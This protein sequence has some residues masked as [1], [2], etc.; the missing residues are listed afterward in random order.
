MASNP[1]PSRLLP[2]VTPLKDVVSILYTTGCAVVRPNSLWQEPQVCLPYLLDWNG[3][4][5][6]SNPTSGL[7]DTSSDSCQHRVM[8]KTHG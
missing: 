2:I 1:T 5:V 3:A 6:D 8:N 7:H 4:A